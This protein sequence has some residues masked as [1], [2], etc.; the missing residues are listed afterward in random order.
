MRERIIGTHFKFKKSLI[1]CLFIIVM[2][3]LML[4]FHQQNNINNVPEHRLQWWLGSIEWDEERTNL[5]GDGITIAILDTGIDFTHN[6]LKSCDYEQI[7]VV[8]DSDENETNHGTAIAGIISGYPHDEKGVLGIAPNS[9][10]ISID[11]TNTETVDI[12]YLIKGIKLAINKNV[13]IINISIGVKEGNDKLYS[14]IKEAYDKDIIVIA[15]AG[16]YMN[17]EILYPAIY[18]E[19][20]AVGAYNKNGDIISPKGDIKNVI[21]MPGANISTCI[22]KNNYAGVQGTSFSTAIT[23]GIMSIVKEK[24]PNADNKKIYTAIDK[25]ILEQNKNK[26]T[27]KTILDMIKE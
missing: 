11:V 18:D 17:N 23:S 20:I 16:N 14:C 3:C 24:Y 2:I 19:V 5:S 13:D 12:D 25:V 7:T 21:F 4:I 6:D 1:I 9:K 27:V 15:S 26:P 22:S 8:D 10:I